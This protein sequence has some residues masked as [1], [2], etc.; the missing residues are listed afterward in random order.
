M[1]PYIQSILYLARTHTDMIIVIIGAVITALSIMLA[2]LGDLYGG[3][4][5]VTAGT[6]ITTLGA[7][8]PRGGDESND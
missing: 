2:V 6:V 1:K 5:G 8:M 3:F 4:W 7:V